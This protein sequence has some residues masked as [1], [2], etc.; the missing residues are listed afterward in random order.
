MVFPLHYV[1]ESLTDEQCQD[2]I[3]KLL[4]EPSEDS[5][6]QYVQ[7]ILKKGNKVYVGK[8]GNVR[9]KI[10]D[11]LHNS[12][13][14]G[15][16]G[17]TACLQRIKITFWWPGMKADVVDIIRGCEVY[18]WSKGEHVQYPGLLQPLAIP[19]QPWTDITMDFIEQL[20]VSE[21]MDTV[22]VVIDR[23]SKYGHFIPL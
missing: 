23:L 11:T 21:G 2:L 22:L 16:S 17:Q 12:A 6:V 7:G 14:G 13:L 10:I 3:G 8:I 18:Q 5:E 15:H 19:N 1:V 20:P 4:L 9:R